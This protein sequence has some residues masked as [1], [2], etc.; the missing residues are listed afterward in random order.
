MGPRGGGGPME[1]VF[2]TG[3]EGKLE[4]ARRK[5]APVGVELTQDAGGYPEVQ[6]DSLEEV[7]RYGARAL[8]ER[9]EAPFVLDD[10]G[11]FVHALGGFPGVY[12]S[13]VH[14]T[15]GL[16]RVVG[17]LEGEVDRSAHFQ[18][19]VAF[20]D[21]G[22]GEVELF[23]GRVDG[24]VAEEVLEGPHGFGYDPVFVPEGFREP[25]SRIPPAEKNR[26]SH[27]GRALDALAAWI[28]ER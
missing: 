15:L 27:R 18:A 17:L 16:P 11:L 12:T 14:R 5:L 28:G 25:F 21:P 26:V 24:T 8:M 1:L 22:T 9:M 6:A 7:A 13:Y 23:T 20:G 19:V 3:N 4:E 2:V 10:S